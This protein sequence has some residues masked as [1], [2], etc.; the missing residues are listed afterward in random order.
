MLIVVPV[1]EIL[2][3]FVVGAS[4]ES[5]ACLVEFAGELLALRKGDRFGVELGEKE[6][7]DFAR[8]N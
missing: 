6:I 3:E 1:P 8:R 2:R 7:G 5:D 4:V